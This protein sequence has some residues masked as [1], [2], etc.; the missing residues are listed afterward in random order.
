M[1]GWDCSSGIDIDVTA[2]F[3]HAQTYLN[4]IHLA[5]LELELL[6]MI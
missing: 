1:M 4:L 6:R 2:N 5:K 3:K